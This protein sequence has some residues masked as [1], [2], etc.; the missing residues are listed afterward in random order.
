MAVAAVVI[1][2]VLLLP[3]K[4][5]AAHRIVAAAATAVAAVLEFLS[6]GQEDVQELLPNDGPGI[7]GRRARY[8][9]QLG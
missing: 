5:Q 1:A 2:A 8:D 3:G 6:P 9:G 7:A 4:Q